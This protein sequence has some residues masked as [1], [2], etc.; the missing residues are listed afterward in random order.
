MARFANKKVEKDKRIVDT[1]GRC[2]AEN[3]GAMLLASCVENWN[4]KPFNRSTSSFSQGGIDESSELRKRHPLSGG[5]NERNEAS[6]KPANYSKM[7]VRALHVRV[8]SLNDGS[9]LRLLCRS[10]TRPEF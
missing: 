2:D 7:F 5:G 3:R 8:L 1:E 10:F 4:C 9:P 6:G